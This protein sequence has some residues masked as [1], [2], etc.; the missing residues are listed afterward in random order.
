[1]AKR[2]ATYFGVPIP[3]SKATMSLRFYFA[4]NYNID[5]ISKQE[6]IQDLLVLCKVL[7]DDTYKILNPIYTASAQYKDELVDSICFVSLSFRI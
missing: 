5:S 7:Q 4:N 1:M 3:L 2:Y 6:S